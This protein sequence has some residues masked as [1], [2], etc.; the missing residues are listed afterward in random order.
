MRGVPPSV[1]AGGHLSNLDIYR[2]ASLK[3]GRDG[4]EA[5]C[6]LVLL[7]G[8]EVTLNIRDVDKMFL[9]VPVTE[10]EAM[11]TRSAEVTDGSFLGST[12]YLV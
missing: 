6:N 4:T 2:L 7:H 1:G 11:A 10:Y 9:A 3:L 8:N 12:F 5:E